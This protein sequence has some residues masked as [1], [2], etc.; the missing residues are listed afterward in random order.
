MT[1][2]P[3]AALCL[4]PD[5]LH[6]KPCWVLATP[7]GGPIASFPPPDSW[8]FSLRSVG[9]QARGQTWAWP[10]RR[11]PDLRL[12][13]P[14]PLHLAAS[15]PLRLDLS[16]TPCLPPRPAFAPAAPS[17]SFGT[18]A[19]QSPRLDISAT[20]T[21]PSPTSHARHGACTSF[22]LSFLVLAL[23]IASP[24]AASSPP[25]QRPSPPRAH[26]APTKQDLLV[27]ATPR[28]PPLY[29]AL[30]QLQPQ[31][32][33]PVP[34]APSSVI[35]STIPSKKGGLSHRLAV[36]E[37]LGTDLL[38]PDSTFLTVHL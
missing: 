37:T 10:G 35:L 24:G 19:Q 29:T 20:L 32:Q 25:S 14:G 28:T 23:R 33:R 7:R 30:L 21:C 15:E 13:A 38:L 3:H 31:P 16:H 26:H 4:S 36:P 8:V 1:S 17:L 22:P 12:A 2:W 9:H 6:P 11:G 34:N 18:A 5:L 27:S